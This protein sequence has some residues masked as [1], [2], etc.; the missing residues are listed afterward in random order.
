[1]GEIW[2]FKKCFFFYK[3][4]SLKKK[5]KQLNSKQYLSRYEWCFEVLPGFNRPLFP[6]L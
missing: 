1:M 5:E 3:R 6:K 4:S 2:I